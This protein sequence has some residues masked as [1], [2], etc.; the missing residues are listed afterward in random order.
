MSRNLISNVLLTEWQKKLTE[1]TAT[2]RW[3]D[4]LTGPFPGYVPPDYSSA[5]TRV[6]YVGKATDRTPSS[7]DFAHIHKYRSSA[8]WNLARSLTQSIGIGRRETAS[9]AWSNICKIG[10]SKGNPGKRLIEAQRELAVRTLKYE[11]SRHPKANLIVFV[12]EGF[13]DDLVYE[14]LGK[15]DVSTPFLDFTSHSGMQAFY[16]RPASEESPAV[17]WVQ[18]PQGKKLT[19][20][21]AWTQQA[22]LLIG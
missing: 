13:A 2:K 12:T 4:R 10:L 21:D 20:L 9:F 18:H 14:S 5:Q 17:L 22:M 15:G 16:S 6:L 1:L 8:F 3:G 11:Y 7:K 19:A